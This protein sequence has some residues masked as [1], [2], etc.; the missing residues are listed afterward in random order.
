MR[1]LQDINIIE[2]SWQSKEAMSNP[3]ILWCHGL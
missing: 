1:S 3:K 2:R